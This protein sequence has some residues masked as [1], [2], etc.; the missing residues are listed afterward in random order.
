MRKNIT[1]A[2]IYLF[3]LGGIS[4]AQVNFI[5]QQNVPVLVGTSNLIMPWAG[6]LTYPMFS[7]FDFNLDGIMDLYCHDR[8]N[9]RIVPFINSGTPNQVSYTYDPQ[10]VKF[11]PQPR[12]W[13]FTY[14]FDCDGKKDF[15]TLNDMYNGI[16]VYRNISTTPGTLQ[17]TLFTPTLMSQ[18]PLTYT[19]IFASYGLVPALSDI[20]NDGDV[21]ILNWNNASGGM[22]EYN[23]NKSVENGFGCDSL[24]FEWVTS[25]WGNFLLMTN[26]NK[27]QLNITCRVGF[28]PAEE[29]PFNLDE[30]LKRYD[31]DP[32]EAARHDDTMSSMCIIDIEGDGDKDLLMGGLGDRNSLLLT[33]GGTQNAANMVSQDTLFPQYDNPAQV[34]SFTTHAYTDVDNDGKKDLIISP[35]YDEDFSGIWLYKNTTSTA[36]PVF[37]YQINNFLQRDMIETGTGAYPAFF[38][39]DADGLTDVIIGNYTYYQ[40]GNVFKSGLSLYR[41]VGTA[42]SPSFQLITRDY[43]GLFSYSFATGYGSDVHPAFGD[44]DGDGDIDMIVGDFNGKLQYFTNTAGAGNPASFTFAVPNYYNIDIGANAAPQLVDLNH[45]GML[46]LVIG[47][48]NGFISYYENTGTTVNP[49]FSSVPTVDS[50]GHVDVSYLSNGYSSPFVFDDSGSYKMLV[51]NELGFVFLYG[52]IDNNLNGT[53]TLLDTIL[54]RTEGNRVNVGMGDINGDSIPDLLVGNYAG[55]VA[56]FYRDNPLATNFP[57]P[58]TAKP[59]FEVF[60]NPATGTATVQFSGINP[61]VKT[62]LNI[63]NATGEKVLTFAYKAPSQT[64]DISSLSA[65]VYILRLEDGRNY[66]VRKLLVH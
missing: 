46:D 62:Q 44:I 22:V 1:A 19:N 7:E 66:I 37:D 23:K 28:T 32:S 41:N 56:L 11:F 52:N 6:G 39:Y 25:C 5:R 24:Q 35:T 26:A 55:G 65:G 64:L 14:D 16:K 59:S 30:A 9:N 20:D 29:Q 45:D 4:N 58:A 57:N 38:D 54:S 8:V 33:N 3:L 34:V 10:Y 48:K 40:P 43:A 42:T 2:V 13:S 31:Y 27:A 12:L 51:G 17:F 61:D 47:R 63:Y 50:L 21:D 18:F 15:F 60:P 49:I 53:F 36:A